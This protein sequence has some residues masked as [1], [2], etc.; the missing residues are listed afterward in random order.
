MTEKKCPVCQNE[1]LTDQFS[2]MVLVLNVEKSEIGK[3]MEIKVPGKY[4]L[5][6]KRAI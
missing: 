6:I 4:A 1:D 5:R 3:L 2:G